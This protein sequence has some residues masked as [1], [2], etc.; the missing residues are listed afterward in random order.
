[1]KLAAH[2]LAGDTFRK[3]VVGTPRRTAIG[4]V[5]SHPGWRSAPFARG[6]ASSTAARGL[7]NNASSR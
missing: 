4:L 3:K 7:I 1:M 2:L 6:L 5:L